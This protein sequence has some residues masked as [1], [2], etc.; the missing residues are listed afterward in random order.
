MFR[1]RD[2]EKEAQK[3]ASHRAFNEEK[4][5]LLQSRDLRDWIQRWQFP[6]E[7]FSRRGLYEV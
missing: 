5:H 2:L 6:R 1:V 4:M 7:G 3:N